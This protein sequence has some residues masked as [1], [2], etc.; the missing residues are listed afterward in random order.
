MGSVER[1]TVVGSGS[2]GLSSL[3]IAS[4][5]SL[6]QG[7]RQGASKKEKGRTGWEDGAVP[8]GGGWGR[9]E[10]EGTWTVGSPVGRPWYRWLWHLKDVFCA[11]S[12]LVLFSWPLE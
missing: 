4:L 9:G 7:S 1:Y 2:G 5:P 11:S 3:P 10:E 12:F 6:G 8:D